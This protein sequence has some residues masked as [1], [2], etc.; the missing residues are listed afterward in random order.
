M[1]TTL[2]DNIDWVGYV[3]WTVR[4]F[5]SFS[6]Y[7]GATYN[8]YLVRDE[9][10]ALVDTVKEHYTD[11]LLRNMAALTD[12]S[13]VDYVVCNHGEPD[14]SSGL[15]KVMSALKNPT[16]ICDARCRA[17]LSAYYDTSAWR[18]KIVKTGDSIS[19]GANTMQF[20]ETPMIH[21]PDSMFTYVPEQKLLF[22]MDAFGQHY[23]SSHRFDDQVPLYDHPAR[24]RAE[25]RVELPGAPVV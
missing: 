15:P 6:T 3:D 13:R 22:S 20:I 25:H 7:R 10:T 19:L 2:Y 8:A 9:K 5:H 23:A 21:W 24:D 4:D 11:D 14:H 12:L 1:N 16:L 18:F 17:T